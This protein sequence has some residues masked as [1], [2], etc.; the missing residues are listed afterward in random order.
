MM[1][2]A[3][4]SAACRSDVGGRIARSWRNHGVPSRAYTED[5]ASIAQVVQVGGEARRLHRMAVVDAVGDQPRDYTGQLLEVRVEAHQALNRPRPTVA[6]DE[7]IVA[8]PLG[9]HQH[10]Q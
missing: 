4:S 6:E 1:A 9:Q 8:D 5:Q 7:V 2:T 3:S 10:R